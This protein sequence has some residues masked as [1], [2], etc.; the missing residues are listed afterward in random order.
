MPGLQKH[1]EWLS[2]G[3]RTARVAY[4]LEERNLPAAK[5][6]AEWRVDPSFNAAKEILANPALKNVFKKAIHKG[7]TLVSVPGAK[8]QT[9]APK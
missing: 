3:R 4:V 7:L 8:G 2:G 5:A 6:G 9:L 1:L